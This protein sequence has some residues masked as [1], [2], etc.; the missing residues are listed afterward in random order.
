MALFDAYMMVDWSAAAVAAQGQGFD[1]DLFLL[2]AP[3]AASVCRCWKIRRRGLPR[4][5]GWAVCWPL[6]ASAV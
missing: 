6:V 3:V 5:T 4:A 1:M 2:S